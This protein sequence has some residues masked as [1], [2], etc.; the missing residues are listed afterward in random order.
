MGKIKEGL[1]QIKTEQL[2]KNLHVCV[3]SDT[4]LVCSWHNHFHAVWKKTQ[5]L[6]F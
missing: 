5:L 4:L 6:L 3:T 1:R 2:F